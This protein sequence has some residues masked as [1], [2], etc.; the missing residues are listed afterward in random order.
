MEANTLTYALSILLVSLISALLVLYGWLK[1][2][3]PMGKSYARM[4]LVITL[5]LIFYS[6][7][8]L[9][10]SSGLHHLFRKVEYLMILALPVTWLIFALNFAGFKGWL[11]PKS[12]FLIGVIPVILY[13]VSLVSPN[14][15]LLV[16]HNETF[17][18]DYSTGFWFY[19]HVAFSFAYFITGTYLVVRSAKRDPLIG[20]KQS[21]IIS[22]GVLVPWIGNITFIFRTNPIQEIDLSPFIFVLS[23]ALLA[24]GLFHNR[25]YTI[26]ALAH[27]SLIE[28]M[29]DG[30]VIID[31][32]NRILDINLA[33]QSIFRTS[34]T[35]IVGQAIDQLFITQPDLI[36]YMTNPSR[37]NQEVIVTYGQQKKYY[38]LD[39]SG[40]YAGKDLYVGKL[41]LFKEITDIKETTKKWEKAKSE[42][43]RADSLKSAFLANLSHE[44]KTPM[45]AIMGFSDLLNDSSVSDEERKEFIDHIRNSGSDLL[46]LID[47]LIDIS[48]LDAG[49]ISLQK[50]PVDLSKMM[51]ELFARIN[52]YMIEV[53]KDHIDLIL[54]SHELEKDLVILTDPDRIRQILYNLLNNAVKFTKRG[55]IEFG[56]VKDKDNTVKFFVKDTGIGIPVEKHTMIF[57]RFGRV[58]SS[59]RQEYSG[60]GL[61][62]ALSR[63]LVKLIGGRIWFD[64]VFG[65]GSS[66]YFSIPLALADEYQVPV[67]TLDSVKISKPEVIPEQVID[68]E[69]ETVKKTEV[70][71]ESP[72]DRIKSEPAEA[73]LIFEPRHAPKISIEE[74]IDFTGTKLLIIEF[75]DMSYL[76]IEMILRPTKIQVIRAKTLTQGLNLLKGGTQLTSIILSSDIPD[77]NLI[78]ACRRIKEISLKYN[79]VAITP[80][81]SSVKRQE[82]LQAGCANV[83]PK[84]IKQKELLAAV[85]NMHKLSKN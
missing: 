76:F 84:P 67:K 32:Q 82:C 38:S 71:A 68:P 30:L 19:V 3:T 14:S 77:E 4:M 79:I 69:S 64:S 42:A 53:D 16:N 65:K 11:K 17:K 73:D 60:T 10:S 35:A 36:Q 31:N 81:A 15:G 6:V 61:G 2:N 9:F 13:I 22:L 5:W 70:R 83:V 45:N 43:E 66:F 63:G 50:A 8:L 1:R 24:W 51:A 54:N 37:R 39:I 46:Q 28:R 18:Y 20:T 78:T 59:N 34:K 33:A 48:K 80:F 85:Q 52:E 72:G 56:Y 49:Q 12:G 44:I 27:K 26:I 21:L 74:E 7:G 57:E 75:D 40:L 29:A 41:M 25:F 47:D 23:G 62:L 55:K 58:S